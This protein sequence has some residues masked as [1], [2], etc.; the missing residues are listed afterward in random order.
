M[1]A[2]RRRRS[3]FVFHFKIACS[4]QIKFKPCNA[5]IAEISDPQVPEIVTRQAEW[6]GELVWRTASRSRSEDV[7]V[8]KRAI[9]ERVRIRKSKDP[10]SSSSLLGMFQSEWRGEGGISFGVLDGLEWRRRVIL[11]LAVGD[12]FNLTWR[13]SSRR[14]TAWRCCPQTRPMADSS[15]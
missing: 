12:R 2:R 3:P 7:R 6:V 15:G 11:A 1:R 10:A 4:I 13:C 8:G 5:L 9:A 14:P